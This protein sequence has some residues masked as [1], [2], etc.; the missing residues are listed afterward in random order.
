MNIL[1][2]LNNNNYLIVAAVLA[3]IAG[4]ILVIAIFTSIPL[5]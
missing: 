2:N 5:C 3:I 1:G 4:S